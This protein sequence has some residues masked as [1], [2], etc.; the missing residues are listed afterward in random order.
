MKISV[1]M[2]TYNREKMVR[3][4]VRDI[5]GQSF[6]DFEF[7]VVNN[8]SADKTSTIIDTYAKSDERIKTV[9][10]PKKVSIGKARNIGLSC[11]SGEFV[12]YVDDDD[13]VEKDFLECLSA[14]GENKDFV[15]CGT[16]EEKDGK[17][18][19]QCV[20]EGEYQVDARQAL[21]EMLKR[22]RV[23]SGMPA[24]LFRREILQMHPFREDCRHEDIHTTYKYL[25]EITQGIIIGAPKYC[26]VRHGDN[27]SYFTTDFSVLRPEQLEEYLTAFRERTEFICDRFP[28]LAGLAQYS[29]WSY[30]LSMCHKIVENSLDSC[31]EQY[32]KMRRDLARNRE[33]F[34]LSPYIKDFEREWIQCV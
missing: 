21:E 22:T 13:R 31:Q 1:I 10:L 5:L 24:K 8:A 28:D 4:M 7:I 29:E 26:C 18:K 15:M 23:R 33:A 27:I 6:H 30:M 16:V 3:N 9:H 11:A 12:T 14:G 34:C 17:R 19:P 25:S 32:E 2:V 20:F